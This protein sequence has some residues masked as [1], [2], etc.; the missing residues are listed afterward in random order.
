LLGIQNQMSSNP[1]KAEFNG[2]PCAY[3]DGMLN[4]FNLHEKEFK[5]KWD[6]QHWNGPCVF[7]ITNLG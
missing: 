3:F 5:A 4:Y 2:A 7:I 1:H 6:N